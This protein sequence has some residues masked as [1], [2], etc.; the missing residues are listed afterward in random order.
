MAFG[1]FLQANTAVDSILGPCVDKD[2]GDTEETLL[3]ITA[4]EVRLSKN[5]ANIIPK[6]EATALAHD[7]L[8][9][10]MCKL[11]ATD[12]NTDG[13]LTIMV[14]KSGALSI[15]MDYVMLSQAAFIS[16][17]TAKDSGFMDI[18]VRSV[19]GTAQ[20]ANDNGADINL[21]LADTNELQG[22]ISGGKLPSQVQGLEVAALVQFQDALLAIV[23]VTEGGTMTLQTL[24][25]IQAA[26]IAGNWRRKTADPTVQELLDADDGTTVILEQKLVRSPSVG[27]DYRAITI[28]I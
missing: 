21:I 5:G 7:E 9:N 17:F 1:G 12:T 28:M 26:W 4:S 22:L 14:H 8:G 20:T 16:M 11:N 10:Y 23:D 15:K 2:D 25:K 3:T 19:A 13:I 6:N 24:L 18:N 27:R